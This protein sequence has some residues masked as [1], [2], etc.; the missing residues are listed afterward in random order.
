[1]VEGLRVGVE[2]I[3]NK[4]LRFFF[5]P[6]FFFSKNTAKL[7]LAAFSLRLVF[8]NLLVGGARSYPKFVICLLSY[9]VALSDIGLAAVLGSTAFTLHVVVGLGLINF[10]RHFGT[11]KEVFCVY[12]YLLPCSNSFKQQ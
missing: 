2:K 6:N 1:M 12:N 8:G 5:S 3:G 7:I 4:R 10:K 11:Q 9:F